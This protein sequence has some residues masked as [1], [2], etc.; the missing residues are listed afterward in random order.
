[1]ADITSQHDEKMDPLFP[2][3]TGD[4]DDNGVSEIESLCLCCYKQVQYHPYYLM[5]AVL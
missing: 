1:M 5:C 3:L 2:E 4:S